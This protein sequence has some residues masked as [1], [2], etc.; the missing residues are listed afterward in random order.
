MP[1]DEFMTS[2]MNHPPE[3]S[4][5]IWKVNRVVHGPRTLTS[6]IPVHV[7]MKSGG[8][9][10]W[11]VAERTIKEMIHKKAHIGISPVGAVLILKLSV[12]GALRVRIFDSIRDISIPCSADLCNQ[13][14]STV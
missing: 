8:K 2:C 6:G 5:A 7:P 3:G 9:T 12:S 1:S 10:T 13:H 11:L 14:A 4:A